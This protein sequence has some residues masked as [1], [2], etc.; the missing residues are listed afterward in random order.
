MIMQFV[1]RGRALVVCLGLALA[2]AACDDGAS[3]EAEHLQRAQELRTAGDVPSAIIELKNA[4][5]ANPDNAD[6]R[7]QLGELY[8]M[9]GDAEGAAKELLRARD[10][11]RKDDGV[12]RLLVQ[13]WLLKGDHAAVLAE[14]PEDPEI[15]DEISGDLAAARGEALFSTGEVDAAATLLRSVV[16]SQGSAGAY[17]GLVAVDLFRN[18]FTTAE[19]DLSAGRQRHPDDVNIAALEG[20]LLARQRLFADAEAAF[21]EA[22]KI[23][24]Q[25]FGARFGLARTLVGQRKLDE[26]KQSVDALAAD[27]PQNLDVTLLRSVV[28]LQSGDYTAAQ[29]DA[30]KVLASD[31]RNVSAQFVAGASSY[32]LNQYEQ[33]VRSLSRYLAQAPGDTSARKLLA[34][35]HLRLGET[36]EAERVLA[37]IGDQAAQDGEYLGLLSTSAALRGDPKQG[38]QY[39][40]QAVV[41]SPEDAA[42]RARLGLMR[43]ATGDLNQGTIDLD[44]AIELDPQLEEDPALDAAE[45]TVIMAHIRRGDYDAAIAA[46]KELQQKHP[47][48]ASGFVL[49][50]IAYMGK[51]DEAEARNAFNEALKIQPGA[52]DASANLAM[53][54]VDA[55]NLAAAE[56]LLATA[57]EHFP[58]HLNTMMLLGRLAAQQGK[59][60]DAK[61]WARKAIEAHPQVSQPRLLL[62]RLLLNEKNAAEALSAVQPVASG[63]R[64]E[65]AVLEVAG[66]AQLELGRTEDAVTSLEKLATAMPNWAQAHFLLAK[67]YGQAGKGSDA[68]QELEKTL[69]IEP[70]HSAAKLALARLLILEGD[71]AAAKP[72]VDDLAEGFPGSPDVALLRADLALLQNDAPTAVQILEKM[73]AGDTSGRVT[74]TLARAQWRS[75][76]RQAGIKTLRDWLENH[77]NDTGMR[78][79]LSR[80]YVAEGKVDEAKAALAAVTE[81]NPQDWVG[82]NEL[83]YLLYEQGDLEAARPLAEKA[84]ELSDQHPMVAD[85]LAVIFLAQDQAEKALPLLRSAAAQLPSLPQ[86]SFHLA[87]ALAG[88]GKSDEAREVLTAV[89]SGSASFEE[90]EKA[91]ALLRE[92]GG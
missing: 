69:T 86:V 17:A 91:E 78:L 72:H 22:L 38:L 28:A 47:E 14:L 85:T 82:R 74:V 58:T 41:R 50:G 9:A 44:E 12:R 88:T 6:T 92:L 79:E 1:A 52:T 23:D 76:D 70:S 45:R 90:R 60:E 16:D 55:G 64:V 83:A 29:Q 57:H 56:T 21:A 49:A 5:Q 7:V 89:L 59:T 68:R 3:A 8:L 39:L 87:Q 40:E 37:E 36:T 32:A 62:A 71:A 31:D 65:P 51:G 43:I 4:L 80:Y 25:H 54:E 48:R 84:Y 63:E 66:M 42:L 13:S 33:A 10:L 73:R 77:P 81:A 34:A 24:P 67:A 19:R 46:A 61:G 27:N 2:L 11:G 26:A 18:D 53:L 20:E 35:S 75:G 30:S 15:T